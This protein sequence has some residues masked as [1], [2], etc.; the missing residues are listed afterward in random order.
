MNTYTYQEFKENLDTI[1]MDVINKK[2]PAIISNIN[3]KDCALLPASDLSSM[4]ESIY[5]LSSR[6]NADRLLR[7]IERTDTSSLPIFTVEQLADRLGLSDT[8]LD[9]EL[10]D[11]D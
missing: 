3:T 4:Q 6:N 1:W 7:A 9:C 8:E 11:W 10:D 2:Q 5:L